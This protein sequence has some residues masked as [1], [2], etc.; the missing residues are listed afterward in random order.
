M[1]VIYAQSTDTG[2]LRAIKKKREKEKKRRRKRRRRRR[3][4][5]TGIFRGFPTRM[6]YLKHGI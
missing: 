5:R 2:H 6:V 1:M 3:S 4:R